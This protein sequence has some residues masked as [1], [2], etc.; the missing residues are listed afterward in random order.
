MKQSK[1][2]GDPEDSAI[3]TL[4]PRPQ[5]SPGPSLFWTSHLPT[6]QSFPLTFIPMAF[7]SEVSRAFPVTNI[8]SHC[9][10]R[11][12]RTK[13]G[14]GAAP[15]LLFPL[16]PMK[17]HPCSLSSLH[18]AGRI[19]SPRALPATG[20]V[21]YCGPLCL[22]RHCGLPPFSPN[23]CPLLE[24]IPPA[25]A[26]CGSFPDQAHYSCWSKGEMGLRMAIFLWP[27]AGSRQGL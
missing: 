12:Y 23:H 10:Q 26:E 8:Q 9:H 18:W 16:L 25:R 6:S 22:C 24:L 27:Q 7:R 2:G 17:C 1:M 3:G 11:W 15:S 14:I 19:N 13:L 21:S 4:V 20:I 5:G